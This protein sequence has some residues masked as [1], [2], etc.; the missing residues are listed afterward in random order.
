MLQRVQERLSFCPVV[1]FIPQKLLKTGSFDFVCIKNLCSAPPLL[2]LLYPPSKLTAVRHRLNV[3]NTQ[4]YDILHQYIKIWVTPN[5]FCMGIK[6]SCQ[7]VY[8]KVP[9]S[10]PN[11]GLPTW[12]LDHLSSVPGFPFYR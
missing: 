12:S 2:W 5:T 3:K 1:W 9:I 8:S 4:H 7:V 10:T 11:S 6:P